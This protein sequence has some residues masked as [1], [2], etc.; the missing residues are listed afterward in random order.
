[1]KRIHG[2]ISQA[3]QA[4]KIIYR[5]Q[6]ELLRRRAE[7]LSGKDKLLLTMYFDNGVTFYQIAKLAGINEGTVSRRINKLCRRLINSEYIKCLQHREMFSRD[8]LAIAKD[9][10]LTG[11][12]IKKIAG[13]HDLTYY[14]VRQTLKKIQNRLEWAKLV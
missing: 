5:N 9:Y 13:E 3:D 6:V 12:S 10:Y 11:R 4:N 7:L 2:N 8:E 1:M 14:R